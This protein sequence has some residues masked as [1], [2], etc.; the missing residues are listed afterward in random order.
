MIGLN[1]VQIDLISR[2][3]PK[4]QYYAMS[5]EGNRLF[6]LALGP[7]ALSFAAQSGANVKKEVQFMKHKYGAQWIDYWPT[8]RAGNG[9]D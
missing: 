7:V 2:A 3:A 6:D 8:N 9:H 5:A 1:Q 4:R